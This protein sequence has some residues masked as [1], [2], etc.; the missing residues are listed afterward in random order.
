MMLDD[1]SHLGTTN[2][3][4]VSTHHVMTLVFSCKYEATVSLTFIWT[5]NIFPDPKSR[6]ELTR[7]LLRHHV[8][9]VTRVPKNN[10]LLS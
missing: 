1:V 10:L 8:V 4:R 7:Q 6:K 5:K 9:K 2:L 3:F